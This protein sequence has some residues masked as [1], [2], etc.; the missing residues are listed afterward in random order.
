MPRNISYSK[1]FN[2]APLLREGEIPPRR[3]LGDPTVIAQS[4]SGYGGPEQSAGGVV[5]L[6]RT[7][8]VSFVCSPTT[9]TNSSLLTR[10]PCYSFSMHYKRESAPEARENQLPT[11]LV[12]GT[13]LASSAISLLYCEPVTSHTH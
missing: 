13:S 8:E 6:L 12:E 1:S 4:T 10:P 7:D 9:L 2:P 11:R 3:H 5:I